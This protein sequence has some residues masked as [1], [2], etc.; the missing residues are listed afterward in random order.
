M[1][2]QVRRDRAGTQRPVPR[3]VTRVAVATALT[4]LLSSLW[5]LPL[6][7]G[8]HMGMD[9]E[10]M[11]SMMAHPFWQ[12]AGYLLTLGVLS[13]TAAMLTLGLVRPWGETWPRWLPVVGGRRI[14]PAAA[15]VPATT[16]AVAVTCLFIPV[17]VA[18]PQ[19]VSEVN[20]WTVLMTTCYAPLVLWGPLLFVVTGAYAWRRRPA[21]RTGRVTARR[22]AA[23]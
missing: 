18:W 11:D 20:G 6:M 17:M 2:L 21:R 19:N 23:G 12:R 8:F 13:E 1:T 14:P 22:G 10:F 15:I 5:R 4:P 9:A 7:F 16:G 3:W